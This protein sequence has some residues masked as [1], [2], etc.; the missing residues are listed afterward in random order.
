MRCGRVV[1]LLRASIELPIL[2]DTENAIE[3]QHDI[4]PFLVRPGPQ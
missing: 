1:V 2:V 3:V 4:Q